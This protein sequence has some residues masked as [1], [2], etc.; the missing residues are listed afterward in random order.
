MSEFRTSDLS[1]R[2]T[3]FVGRYFDVITKRTKL[4]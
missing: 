4:G 1:N 3:K 2:V